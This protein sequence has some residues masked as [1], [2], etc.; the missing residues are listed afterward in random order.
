MLTI[1]MMFVIIV[2]I[3][4]TQKTICRQSAA[5]LTG[6]SNVLTVRW[7]ANHVYQEDEDQAAAIADIDDFVDNFQYQYR[8]I[9]NPSR[10]TLLYLKG[11]IV[12]Y[13]LPLMLLWP[14]QGRLAIVSLFC[15]SYLYLP[16]IPSCLSH[17]TAVRALVWNNGTLLCK[18]NFN[19]NLNF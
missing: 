7:C 5:R 19:R 12:C 17:L 9:A 10:C 18:I 6:T 14:S 2:E 16:T 3:I 15:H 11:H 1:I 13:L 4:T 8:F